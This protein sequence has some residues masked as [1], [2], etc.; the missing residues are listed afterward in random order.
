VLLA[1]T[2]LFPRLPLASNETDT[3]MLAAYP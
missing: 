3:A 2:A 1:T